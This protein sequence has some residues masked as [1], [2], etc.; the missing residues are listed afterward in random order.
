MHD[1]V[2]H[3]LKLKPPKFTGTGD[4]EVATR[5]IEELKKAFELLKCSEKEKV[6]L[7]VYQMQGVASTWW[8]AT[9]REVFPEGIVPVWNAFVRAFNDKYFSNCAKQLK[10]AEFM[11]LRQGPMIVDQYK[12]TSAKLSQYAP[13]L[14]QD[15][16]E[17]AMRFIDGLQPELKDPLVPFDIK[18][19][20]E[21]YGRA[22]LIEKNL[23]E[24]AAASRLR[25]GSNKEGNWFGKKPMYGG[26]YQVPPN[27]KG[28]FGKSTPNQNGACRFCGRRHGT[29]PCYI[30]MGA[31][32][33]CGQ[34]GHLAR[35]CPRKQRQTQQL[36]PPPPLQLGQNMGV[37]AADRTTG[38]TN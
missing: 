1:L 27:R 10:M 29:A 13:R 37:C 30:R 35:D 19:Y 31:C 9:G 11:R 2:E 23:N 7:A 33:E 12:A 26:R 6:T 22:Q 3:F 4:P 24:R 18:N 28:G 21:L 16:E 5:W 17:K 32:Y 8:R 38:W 36:P 20:N 34:Q 25:F 14:I 15:P